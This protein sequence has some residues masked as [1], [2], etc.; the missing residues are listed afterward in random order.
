MYNIN[1]YN[2]VAV[3]GLEKLAAQGYILDET[4]KPDAILMRSQTIHDMVFAESIVAIGRA[5]AGTDNIPVE[6]CSQ[7]G[8]VVFNSPGANSNSVKELTMAMLINLSRHVYPSI[9][10]TKKLR[11]DYVAE[12]VEENKK[13][14]RGC[15]VSSATLGVIGLGNVGSKVANAGVYLGM[16]VMGYDPYIK[17]KNAWEIQ[18]DV[19]KV[20]DVND[21]FSNADFITI[22]TPA[23]AETDKMIGE[24]AIALAKAGVIILNYAREEV[25]DVDAIK[26]GLDSGKIAAYATDFAVPE[27]ADYDN[28]LL[29]PHIGGTTD[30]AEANCALMA[31]DSLINFLETGEIKNAVNF[32]DVE[33]TLVSPFRLSIINR[34]IPNMVGLI[35][36][37]L[38]AKGINIAN[39]INRSQGDFAYNLVDLDEADESLILGF[40]AEIKEQAGILR[41]RL[42]KN[43]AGQ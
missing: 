7:E 13:Q 28:V 37:G 3:E 15:E 38:A 36:T 33:M 9:N 34:N 31:A 4:D 22:H 40:I 17:V 24:E 1:T 6:R 19:Y 32:P 23:T 21:I 2:T 35:S 25:V 26:A 29:T 18:K 41:V 43:S 11:G 8:I 27:L 39:I 12:L 14:F 20:A 30:R 10:W 16:H 5:G 42:I